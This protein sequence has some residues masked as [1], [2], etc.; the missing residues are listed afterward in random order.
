MAG[1]V[2]GAAAWS[3][4]A[5][6]SPA[7]PHRDVQ[8]ER[9][10]HG[11]E[12]FD[13]KTLSELL[14]TSP[15][16]VQAKVTGVQPGRTSGSEETGGVEQARDVT[17]QV[18]DTLKNYQGATTT[19]VMEEYGWDADGNGYQVENVAWSDVGD[20]GFYFLRKTDDG[21]R[22]RLVNTQSRALDKGGWLQ[23]SAQPG[24]E[25]AAAL[26]GYQPDELAYQI[27]WMLD[28]K[29]QQVLTPLAEPTEVTG[30]AAE[31][32]A[33]DSGAEEPIPDGSTN[34]GSEPTPYPS[35]S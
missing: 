19:L 6:G 25:L 22:W 14:A 1:I 34:D 30:P 32:P 33:P 15:V 24:S 17:L 18:T 3:G 35:S 21:Q 20:T 27:R 2:V 10:L 12:V 28:K 8:A 31:S 26:T 5:D 9:I 7:A 16:V 29:N 23:S 11:R 4:A 13:F